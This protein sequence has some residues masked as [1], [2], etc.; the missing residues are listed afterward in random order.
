MR[1][2]K[3]QKS[4]WI[5]ILLL[6]FLVVALG[7]IGA[8]KYNKIKQDKDLDIFQQGAQYGYEQVIIQISGMAVNC[9]QVPLRIENQTIN[10]IA[11]DCLRGNE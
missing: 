4:S 6:I 1:K 5:I 8:E 10:M 2:T 9:E 7:Y 3:F 11:V